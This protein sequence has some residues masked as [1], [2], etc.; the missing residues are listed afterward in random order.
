MTDAVEASIPIQEEQHAGQPGHPYLMGV[1]GLLLLL[2]FVDLF[3]S[4]R[5]SASLI[6]SRA[7]AEA[8]S[9]TQLIACVS[10]QTAGPP[11][12]PTPPPGPT[13]NGIAP[14]PRLGACGAFPWI[15]N[16]GK[17]EQATNDP[18]CFGFELMVENWTRWLA[19]IIGA[20]GILWVLLGFYPAVGHAGQTGDSHLGSLAGRQILSRVMTAGIIFYIAWRVGD[21]ARFVESHFSASISS[22][23]TG[24]DPAGLNQTIAPLLAQIAGLLIQC[25]LLYLAPRIVWNAVEVIYD[26]LWG[27]RWGSF[28]QENLRAQTYA[29]FFEFF[30]LG[31]G[32]VWAPSFLTWLVNFL[33][34]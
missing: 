9:T 22:G 10:T 32:I 12:C 28:K 1:M 6:N 23:P 20:L 19:W 2:F 17:R 4:A 26:L 30:A 18:S 27:D 7:Q 8:P 21:I 14:D 5:A 13:Y 16:G 11:I 29:A 3:M 33:A 34:S 24:T 25:F 15:L 31:V